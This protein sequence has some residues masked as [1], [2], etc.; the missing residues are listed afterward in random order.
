MSAS[1]ECPKGDI[2]CAVRDG[3][4]HDECFPM[5]DD[6]VVD[7]GTPLDETRLNPE[8]RAR[9]SIAAIEAAAT[10]VA[11]ALNAVALLEDERS[12][13]K[14]QAIRRLMESRGIAATPAEKIIEEDAEYAA[15]RAKQRDAEVV[16]WAAAAAYESAKL[17][18]RLDVALVGAAGGGV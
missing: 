12:L 11:D 14:P 13:I 6:E 16:K 4:S 2:F 8:Q 3:Q 15:H 10:W 5:N 1:V 7:A 18:A 17:R 9:A